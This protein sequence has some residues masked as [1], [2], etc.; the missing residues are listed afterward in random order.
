[1][2]FIIRPMIESD[3]DTTLVWRNDSEVRKSALTNDI[4]SHEEHKAMYLYNNAIKLIFEVNEYLVGYIQISI[5]P[6]TAKG[7]WAFHMNPIYKGKGLSTIMLSSALYY[8]KDQ[9]KEL[10]ARVK[11]DNK[12]S[13]HLHYKL[14]FKCQYERDRLYHFTKEL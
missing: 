3:L 5:D 13:I 14:G 10:E 12:V 8:L 11:V 6:D 4:I 1:M 9:Y 7:E 2:E